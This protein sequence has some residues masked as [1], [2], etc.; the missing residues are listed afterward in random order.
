MIPSAQSL[1]EDGDFIFQ[2]DNDPKHT[3]K[4]CREFLA[5]NNITRMTWPPQSPDLNPIE[6]LWAI[7]NQKAK[8]RHPRSDNELFD[9]LNT[10]WETMDQDILKNLVASMP[11][12]CRKVI[13][14]HGYP[15]DY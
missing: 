8:D 12:R 4:V 6:N 3:A 10:E 11:Q 13:A 9:I 14:N 15:I 7:L 2:E 5:D 1:F